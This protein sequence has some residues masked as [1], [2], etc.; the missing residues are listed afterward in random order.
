MSMMSLFKWLNGFQRSQAAVTDA[1]WSTV[2]ADRR[3]GEV[4]CHSSHFA[5]TCAALI[6][7]RQH[8]ASGPHL[9]KCN[10]KLIATIICAARSWVAWESGGHLA[11]RPPPRSDRAHWLV[12][13]APAIRRHLEHHVLTSSRRPLGSS[14]IFAKALFAILSI[15]H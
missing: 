13:I 3:C 10:I 15:T 8:V 4:Q 1:T 14:A 11:P 7:S 2:A 6:L 5:L 9:K 12:T